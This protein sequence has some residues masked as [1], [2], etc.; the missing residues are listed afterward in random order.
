M[1]TGILADEDQNAINFYLDFS[2][3]EIIGQNNNPAD[4]WSR[5]NDDVLERVA[6]TLCT[7]QADRFSHSKSARKKELLHNFQKNRSTWINFG[8]NYL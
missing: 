5:D 4:V 8:K 2:R 6:N 7:A 1:I 3:S